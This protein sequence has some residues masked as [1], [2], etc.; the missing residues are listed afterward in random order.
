MEYFINAFKQYADFTGR[1]SRQDY[2]MFI[3]FYMIFLVLLGVLGAMLGTSLLTTLFSLVILVPSI[4]ITARR[5][6]DIGRSGWWQLIGLLPLIGL[7]VMIIFL[8]QASD[9]DN[10]Y[11]PGPQG[12]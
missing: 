11:G 1:A 3:V 2:W 9:E 6:H 5:L 10:E 12:M 7:I 4:S 8:V